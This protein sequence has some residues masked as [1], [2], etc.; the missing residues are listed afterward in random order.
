LF[1]GSIDF[2]YYSGF[3]LPLK[4]NLEMVRIFKQL[5]GT[6]IG[7]VTIGG[8]LTKT[9][10]INNETVLPVRKSS[11]GALI[12]REAANAALKNPLNHKIIDN[13]VQHIYA[14]AGSVYGCCTDELLWTTVFGNKKGKNHRL[15]E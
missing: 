5:N 12:S 14:K 9:D 11:M 7:E 1:N 2:Q 8:R 3:D 4:T 10:R 13:V 6:N 15:V